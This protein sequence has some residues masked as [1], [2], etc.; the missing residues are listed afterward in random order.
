MGIK[1]KKILA[2]LIFM[3]A[4]TASCLAYDNDLTTGKDWVERM[5]QRE[6]FMSLI[7]PALLFS[8][9]NVHLR[10][11]LPQYLLLIDR[12]MER[13]PKLESEGLSNIFASTIY[14][15]EPQNREALK[16]M[17]LNFLRGNLETKPYH[18]PR[19]TIEDIL[20]EISG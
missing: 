3:G 6:K 13:N 4:L 1:M 19:L 16:T 2:A 9:Y 17:E 8:E 7:P 20:E 18:T 14:F 5:S 10:L 15:F 11:S 12:V